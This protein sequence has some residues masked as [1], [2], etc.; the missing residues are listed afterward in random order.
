MTDPTPDDSAAK[1]EEQFNFNWWVTMLPFL[2][3]I[4][5]FI[6]QWSQDRTNMTWLVYSAIALVVGLV[7]G[8]V[9]ASAS[10]SGT[11]DGGD[12]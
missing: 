1:Q 3:A 7:L 6:Y 2:G 11:A 4:C 10:S 12:K 8:S 5:W 9:V